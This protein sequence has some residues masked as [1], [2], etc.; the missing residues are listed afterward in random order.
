[1][2]LVGLDLRHAARLLW[3]SPGF[4][5][6]AL[7]ALALGMGAAS[8]LFSVVDAVL[9]KPLPFREPDRLVV[10]WEKNPAQNKFRLFAAVANFREWCRQSR[11]FEAMAAIVAAR[12]NLTAGPS[13]PIEPEELKAERVSAGLF[14]LLGVRASVGRTFQ[15]G[16]DQAGHANFVLLSHALW[17]RRFG[18]DP[19]IPGKAIRLRA[20][21]YTVVGVLPPGFGILDPSVD[22]WVPLG[23]N[24]DDPR[25]SADRNVVVVAR[26]AR[27]I[28]ID[29]ARAEMD[30]IGDRLEREYPALNTGWRPSIFPIED[31]LVGRVRRALL[32]LLAAVGCLLLMACGNVANL[33]L[34]RAASRKKEIAIRSALGAGTSRIVR[35]LLSESL[36]LALLGGALGLLVARGALAVITALGPPGIPR[37]AEAR[38]DFRLFVVAFVVSVATG[39]LFGLAPALQAANPDLQLALAEGGRS[40]KL[41]RSGRALRNGLV[42]TEIALAVVVLIGA[43]LLMRSFAALTSADSGFQPSGLLT[44]RVPLTHAR[45]TSPER[46][47]SSFQQIADG[48]AALPGVRSVAAVSALPLTGL[49]VG[50]TFG[51][52]GR[53][54]PPSQG[55][56]CLVRAI[57]PPYFRVMAI[58]LKEGREFHESDSAQAPRVVIIDEAM[59]RRF[60]LDSPLGQ[61]LL[62][63][64]LG[65]AE[66]VGVVGNVK[67]D[68][69]DGENWPTIYY[70]YAQMPYG[71]MT[72]VLR[73][74]VPPLSLAPAVARAVHQFDPGQPVA[75]IRTME[76]VAG[77][78]LAA[79]RFNT[80]V[81]GAFAVIAFALAAVGIYGVMAYDVAQRTQEIGVRMALG[82]QTHDV[83]KL[84]LGQGARLAAYGIGAGLAAAYGLTRWM[85]A[86]LYGVKATDALTFAFIALLLAAVALIASYLPSRRAMALHPVTALRHE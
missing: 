1:M 68:R 36:L 78:A 47:I 80:V 81:L 75:D 20:Q 9:F 15:P 37:L 12:A 7:L 4:T 26:L 84:I 46:R 5:L 60:W 53:P 54:T 30:T 17:T 48:L 65:R 58:A 10:V 55:P 40:G 32:V 85:A 3:K 83:L 39:V 6:A 77:Q 29:Q 69:P 8:G 67:A 52:D 62:L 23:M 56:L 21:S 49:G 59:A 25:I 16:E 50:D 82:A 11:S 13:G 79:P 70:P 2:S 63:A 24:L 35:Q 71:T 43:G 51:I 76:D 33:L 42:V 61:R 44:A 74:S 73:A 66:I 14:P 34:A 19:S 27:G 22:A 64:N 41:G 18:G 31:E 57:T 72:M 28:G 86:M 38:L 45:S